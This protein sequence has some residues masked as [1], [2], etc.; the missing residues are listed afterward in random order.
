[1]WSTV[2]TISRHLVRLTSPLILKKN[3]HRND[4]VSGIFWRRSVGLPSASRRDLAVPRGW[5]RIR[6]VTALSRTPPLP[7]FTYHTYTISL[8]RRV[9]ILLQIYSRRFS[10]SPQS[11]LQLH[12]R[13]LPSTLY[14]PF[15]RKTRPRARYPDFLKTSYKF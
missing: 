12:R 4:T 11:L 7:Q 13:F 3:F 15:S 10:L 14:P 2:H 5:K 6:P 8:V 1:M 9:C